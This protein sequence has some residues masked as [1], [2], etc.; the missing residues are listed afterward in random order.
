MT[1]VITATK[2]LQ[3]VE[4]CEE[5]E[6][7]VSRPG[8]RLHQLFQDLSGAFGNGLATLTFTCWGQAFA[9]MMYILDPKRA[10][11]SYM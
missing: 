7:R 9:A 3:P 4:D 10:S 1:A 5:W 6:R 8:L 11:P 2:Q